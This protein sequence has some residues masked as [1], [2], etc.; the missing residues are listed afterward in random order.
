VRASPPPLVPQHPEH[1]VIDPAPVD[2]VV[3]PQ[4]APSSIVNPKVV[5]HLDLIVKGLEDSVRVVGDS[6]RM[7]GELVRELATL[8]Q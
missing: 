2:H 8:R 6:G 1:D 3:P 7:L 5:L 4:E